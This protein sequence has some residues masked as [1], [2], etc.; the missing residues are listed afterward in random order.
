MH[1]YPVYGTSY[2]SSVEVE[3]EVQVEVE[4]EVVA[5]LSFIYYQ[6]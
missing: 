5:T 3:V 1:S 6:Q 4:I 2:I